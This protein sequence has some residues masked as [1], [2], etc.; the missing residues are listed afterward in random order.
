MLA[1]AACTGGPGGP[2]LG[3]ITDQRTTYGES[4]AVPLV[5]ASDEPAAVTVSVGSS[6]DQIVP[7]SGLVVTGAGASRTLTVTPSTITGSV[8]VTVTAQDVGGQSSRQ[9]TVEV[10]APFQGKG[11]SLEPA[12]GDAIGAAVALGDQYAVIGG[13]ESVYVYQLVGDA[14]IEMQKL[15]AS[16][17]AP[18]QNFG[19]AV[20]IDGERIIVGADGHSGGGE[21]AGAAYIFELVDGNWV[22]VKKL[23]DPVPEEFD[24]FGRSVAIQGDYAFVGAQS[25]VNNGIQGGSVFVYQLMDILGWDLYGKLAP[26]DANV[27]D[28]FGE[29]VDTDGGLLIVGSYGDADHGS[30]SGAANIFKVENFV[31]SEVIELSPDELEEGDQFGTRVAISGDYALVAA[32]SDDDQGTDTGAVYVFH[33]P[34]TGWQQVDKLYAPDPNH[35]DYFGGSLDLHYP[36]ALVGAHSDDAPFQ[37][38]GSV[39]V[40]RHDGTNWQLVAD[41]DSPAPAEGGEFGWD[42]ATNGEFIIASAFYTPTLTAV[43]GR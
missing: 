6:N 39:F 24:S 5:I 4:V 1:L 22:E 32:A 30:E 33:D 14:W 20:A 34:G 15:T 27:N 11:E 40:Y 23:T 17:A 31:W 13:L 3:Q 18:S 42:A 16:D 2:A 35:F 38:A 43:F 41:L 9:F 10:E 36:Y 21:R 28:V 26:A 37:N 29:S 7:T 25:D 12:N 8:T 19:G